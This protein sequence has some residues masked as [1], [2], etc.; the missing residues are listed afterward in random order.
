MDLLEY[1]AKELF[2]EVGIPV[3]PSQRINDTRDL[4][5]LQIPYPVVLKSQVRVGGRGR[6]GGVRFVENTIDAIAAAR[7]I[8]NLPIM[9]QYPQVLL[10]ESRYDAEMEF[11][12]AIVLDYHLQCPVLLGSSAGGIHI[13]LLLEKMQKVVVEDEFSPFYARRLAIA[14]GLKGSLIQS[15]SAIIE[16]MYHLFETKDLDLIEINPLGISEKGE[17]MALDGKISINDYAFSRHPE[18]LPLIAPQSP[19]INQNSEPQ[20]IPQPQQLEWHDET[21][22]IAIICNNMSLGISTWDLLMQHQYKANCCWL[23]GE[24]YQ[25]NLVPS[26]FLKEQLQQVIH[27]LIK[28]PSLQVIL[29]NILSS[30]SVSTLIGKTLAEYFTPPKNQGEKP[31]KPSSNIHFPQIIVRVFGGQLQPYQEHL[32]NLPIV[33]TEDIEEVVKLIAFTESY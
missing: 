29:I 5:Q 12:L 22:N 6:A 16:K 24:N 4:K 25:E 18:I 8:F 23:I 28:I 7:T 26:S 27:K 10:A 13:E 21:G 30:P 2:Q 1:Q 20:N 14:M 33:W 3:L 11:F 9:G 17:V 31:L 15:V 32:I 19:T